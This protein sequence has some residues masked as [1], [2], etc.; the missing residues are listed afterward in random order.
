MLAAIA[1]AINVA[2]LADPSQ[3]VTLPECSHHLLAQGPRL[4]SCNEQVECARANSLA[5]SSSKWGGKFTLYALSYRP[6]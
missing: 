5:S 6:R 3:I 2:I 4:D 1:V